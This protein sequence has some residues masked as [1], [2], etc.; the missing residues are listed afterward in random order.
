MIA[1]GSEARALLA[2]PAT[3]DLAPVAR[4]RMIN[5][6][7]AALPDLLGGPIADFVQKRAAELVEDHARLRAARENH[8]SS[9]VLISLYPFAWQGGIIAHS[10]LGRH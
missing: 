7:K 10:S 9:C 6:A 3:A 5:T 4:D 2:S 1:S 8:P